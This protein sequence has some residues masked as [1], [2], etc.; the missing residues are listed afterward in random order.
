[1]NKHFNF[2]ECCNLHTSLQS[3]AKQHEAG[4]QDGDIKAEA[5][6]LSFVTEIMKRF[7]DAPL[8]SNS[9]TVFI[10]SKESTYRG[11]DTS[12]LCILNW[13]SVVF[14]ILLVSSAV[15]FHGFLF[16]CLAP[17]VRFKH[18]WPSPLTCS[19]CSC[20]CWPRAEPTW[21]RPGHRRSTIR[22]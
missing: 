18:A 6:N 20:A 1:M 8:W 9:F 13:N 3:G 10:F 7:L 17:A 5:C 15:L 4:L 11:L 21:A 16:W 22:W 2:P 12:F 14:C 19:V